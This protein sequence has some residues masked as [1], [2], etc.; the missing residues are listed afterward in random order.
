MGYTRGI[1]IDEKD[2]LLIGI[3]GYVSHV[4]PKQ[5]YGYRIEEGSRG[6]IGT[7]FG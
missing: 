3:N 4:F 6:F 2:R 5:Q 1:S 7:G